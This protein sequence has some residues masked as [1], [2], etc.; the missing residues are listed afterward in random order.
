MLQ[1]ILTILFPELIVPLMNVPPGS[2]APFPDICKKLLNFEPGNQLPPEVIPSILS[3][4]RS[5]ILRGK[6]VLSA[7]IEALYPG[8]KVGGAESS[9]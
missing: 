6:A 5:T 7:G 9:R 2:K 3:P 8:V 1:F 4:G